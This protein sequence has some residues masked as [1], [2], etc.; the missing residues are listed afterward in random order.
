M[1][2][3]STR[4]RLVIEYVDTLEMLF[5]LLHSPL[6]SSRVGLTYI[7]PKATRAFATA[8]N[9]ELMFRTQIVTQFIYFSLSFFR[10]VLFRR[11]ELKTHQRFVYRY[12]LK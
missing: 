12:G 10:D 2:S 9:D 11:T 3:D 6:L 4:R 8:A 1:I 7:S 5:I